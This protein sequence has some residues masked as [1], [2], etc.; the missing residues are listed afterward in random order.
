[1]K[2]DQYAKNYVQYT[3]NG[4]RYLIIQKTIKLHFHSR[5]RIT[6][7]KE[8]YLIPRIAINDACFKVLMINLT[9]FVDQKLKD[10]EDLTLLKD[11]IT[12]LNQIIANQLNLLK[13][14]MP[15]T[16]RGKKK[17]ALRKKTLTLEMPFVHNFPY[18]DDLNIQSFQQKIVQI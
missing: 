3:S 10:I 18:L 13:E 11:Q 15:R 9:A 16:S 8:N 2:D 6:A 7:G 5:Q 4:Q 17:G 12:E 1:M 14:N